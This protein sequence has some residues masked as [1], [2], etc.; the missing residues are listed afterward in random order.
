[1]ITVHEDDKE[2]RFYF[3]HFKERLKLKRIVKAEAEE[4]KKR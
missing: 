1:M 3:A 4:N 2:C